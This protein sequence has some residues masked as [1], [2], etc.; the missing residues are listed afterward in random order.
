MWKPFLRYL[1]KGAQFLL[2]LGVMAGLFYLLKQDFEAETFRHLMAQA[3][4][5]WLG[6]ALLTAL[7]GLLL[8]AWRL[9]VLGRDFGLSHGVR[10]CFRIQV[11][12]ISLGMVTPGRAGE[13]SK[14]F[15][16]AQGQQ[17][18]RKTALWIL[19]IERLGDMAVLAG[20]SFAYLIDAFPETRLA[21]AGLGGLGALTGVA[22]YVVWQHT[23][24]KQHPWLRAL[25]ALT[26]RSLMAMGGLTLFAW[27][28]DGL[29]QWCI[30]ASIH[31]HLPLLMGI[32][33]NAVVA[34]AG[35]FSLLPIGLGT[36]DLSALMLYAHS[37]GLEA[38]VI[39]F[40]LGAGRVLGLGLLGVLW[41]GLA[42]RNPQLIRLSVESARQDPP[43]PPEEP[44]V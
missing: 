6:A 38:T 37:A 21:L 41:G 17:T 8:K 1:L 11:I 44:R 39:V 40:L 24:L 4:Y 29:F 43:V 35:I 20:L 13:L 12:S 34:I 7:L 32:G 19:L 10:A 23:P 31:Q 28:L 42:L 14:V 9:Q 26:P 15:L 18:D 22:L 33:L 27:G 5:L 2:L 30:L 3:Q 16:L 25:H 36:V